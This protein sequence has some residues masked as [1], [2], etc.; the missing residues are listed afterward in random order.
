[1]NIFG[2][3][4]DIV[5]CLRIKSVIKK[6]PNFKKRIFSNIEIRACSKKKMKLTVMQKNLL[7]KKLS[8]KLSVWVFQKV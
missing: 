1:M 5:D 8:L 6:N 3:G 7:Q 2:T 4:I